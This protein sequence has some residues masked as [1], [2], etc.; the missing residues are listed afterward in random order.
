MR[1]ARGLR[2]QPF[3][4]DDVEVARQRR[5]ASARRTR[6]SPAV[7]ARITPVVLVLLTLFVYWRV[8][9]FEF[10]NWDDPAYVTGNTQVQAGLSTST[11]WWALTTMQSPYWHPLTW[12]SHLLDVTL[13][14][15]N[16][17]PHHVTSL[18]LHLANTLLLFVGLRRMTGDDGPSAFAAALF[19]VHPLH[20]ESVAWVA[21][22]KDVLSSFFLILTIWAYIRYCERRSAQ[23]F[24]AVA[25]AYA[26]ALMSKPMVVTLPF[27][28][29]LLDRWPLRR[30]GGGPDT[31]ATS[32]MTSLAHCVLEKIPLLAMAA[33]T[34]VATVI[35]QTNVGA[36][37]GLTA[38]P[39]PRRMATAL[40]GCVG[41][42]GAAVWPAHLAA[43]YPLREIAGWQAAAASAILIAVTVA[44]W[45][46]RRSRP[47]L[48]VGWLWYLITIAP[49]IG[50]MQAGEQARADR[51]VY[52]P[53]VGLFVIAAWGGRDLQRRLALPPR[54]MGAMAVAIIAAGAWTARAQAAT[55]SDSSTLWLHATA[56][57]HGN[58]VAYENLAQAQRE[59][60]QLGDA[61]TNYRR[62]LTLAPAQSPRYESIIHNSLG[63]V[64]QQQGREQESHL[65]FAEAVRLSP[66]FAEGQNNLANTLAA[67]GAL[68]DAIPHYEAAIALEPASTEPRVGLGAVLLRQ[69]RPAEAI[70]QYRDALRL[71]F[72]LAEAH[73]GIGGAL[74]IEG[75]A[76]EAM[77]EYE[78]ALRLKPLPSAH[79]NIALLLIRQG[80]AG[81][82]RHHLE[83]ALSIDPSYEPARQALAY[84]S[85]K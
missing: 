65:Q 77:A 68:A 9:Y 5:N 42:L 11:L 55:W 29:L 43:F 85:A 41:Y 17:G 18:A 3:H 75:K 31:P 74:A 22:R 19:A 35:V 14:G 61:E 52:M 56:V 12:M 15:M 47:Y 72:R 51:F 6:S 34:A 39:L 21:E 10:V 58:Y 84:L 69:Q 73:N 54:A 26:L 81:E 7:L 71:D 76:G 33:A 2:P 24:L 67:A 66:G 62:A 46:L 82:A 16:A 49:V 28:L 83:T 25:G 60:G 63:L 32:G 40:V 48:V 78:E 30:F 70:S 50:L 44:A 27:V 1:R 36:V 4:D 53:I 38:L 23:R 57:T 64:L 80:M 8:Q 59:R 45:A 37:A 13:Y 79:L 20:V